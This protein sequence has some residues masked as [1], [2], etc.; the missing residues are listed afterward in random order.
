MSPPPSSLLMSKSMEIHPLSSESDLLS[1]QSMAEWTRNGMDVKKVHFVRHA[2]GTH[3]VEQKYRCIS[4]LDARLTNRGEKQCAD[5]AAALQASSSSI[6]DNAELVVTSPLT[7]C[8]QTAMQCFPTL[9]SSSAERKVPFVA[10]ESIRETVNYNCDRR[11]PTCQIVDEFPMVNFDE[12]SEHPDDPIWN[13]YEESLAGSDYYD[14]HRE[15]AELHKVAERG[16]DFFHWLAAREEKEIVVCTHSAFLRCVLSWGLKGGV[17]WMPPQHL[18]TRTQPNKEDT[19]V[20][21]YCGD[22]AFETK[23]RSDY[24]NC[25]LKSFL[26]VT[27][28]NTSQQHSN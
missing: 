27:K 18:D 7:R 15:S 24:A 28:N 12:L 19:P 11:R 8:I 22:Q 2:E 10:L 1:K 25:E 26:L 21:T 23:M 5:L 17:Q 3:N 4:N 13:A 9:L 16:R 20:V 6:L 14:F